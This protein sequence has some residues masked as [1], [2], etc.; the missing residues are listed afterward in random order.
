M[1]GDLSKALSATVAVLVALGSTGCMSGPPPITSLPPPPPEKRATGPV[2]L[3]M[4][5]AAPSVR[6]QQPAS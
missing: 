3:V 6:I 2:A 1:R 5:D 4:P